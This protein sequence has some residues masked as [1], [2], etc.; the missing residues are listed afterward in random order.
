MMTEFNHADRTVAE[1]VAD[2]LRDAFA[3]LA[4]SSISSDQ[5]V[6]FQRRLLAIT[7]AAKRDVD[8]AHEQLER[9]RGDLHAAATTGK[10]SEE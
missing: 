6:T 1:Q 3:E 10:S 8:R 9:L 7:T 4:A 2:E 5:R